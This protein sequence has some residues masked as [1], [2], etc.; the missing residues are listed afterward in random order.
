VIERDDPEMS[1]VQIR[2]P[3][4]LTESREQ[5]RVIHLE[6]SVLQRARAARNGFSREATFASD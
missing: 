6:G 3:L 2:G 1:H 4:A 5:I